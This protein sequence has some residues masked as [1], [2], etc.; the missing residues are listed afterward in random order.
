MT[1]LNNPTHDSESILSIARTLNS[2]LGRHV[3]NCSFSTNLSGR[4]YQNNSLESHK[5]R[6]Q[7]IAQMKA[8]RKQLERSLELEEKKI[9]YLEAKLEERRLMRL[10]EEKMKQMTERA[11]I[12]IQSQI[13]RFL[14]YKR[15]QILRVENEI[16]N[17]VVKF[18]QALFR[19]RRDRKRVNNI[20]MMIIKH[21]KEERAAIIIQS[22]ARRLFAK[23][24]LGNK[25][26]ERNLQYN[27]AAICLQACVRGV[28]DRKIVNDLINEKATVKIQS[29]YRGLIGRRI[30]DARIKALKKKKERATRIPLHERR[31][32][33]Y[34]VE[35]TRRDSVNSMRRFSEMIPTAVGISTERRLN[36]LE[37][38]RIKD[39]RQDQKEKDNS[40]INIPATSKQSAQKQTDFPKHDLEGSCIILPAPDQ[41]KEKITLSRQKA[42]ARVAKLKRQ[43]LR[44]KERQ[45]KE[46]KDRKK[47][48]EQMELE[49]RNSMKQKILARKNKNTHETLN[50]G[51]KQDKL[52]SN[53]APKLKASKNDDI[54]NKRQLS[55]TCE[56]N[57]STSNTECNNLDDFYFDDDFQEN[58]FDLDGI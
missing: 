5:A 6:A 26:E 50:K 19:G 33:T 39:T 20:K 52:E 56:K 27:K 22:S 49:R 47:V 35:T 4:F 11:A 58:E 40:E 51:K 24:E 54:C 1:S 37:M 30:R 55:Q 41:A 12:L 29:L 32:S 14:S 25:I 16:I 2:D 53:M 46:A 23:N 15:Y 9:L 3:K 48:V 28:R 31:Y 10:Q 13:R 57:R 43:T 42:A 44:E 36:G 7:R 38:L 8:K 17:Y 21:R 34:S 45:Q 18:V